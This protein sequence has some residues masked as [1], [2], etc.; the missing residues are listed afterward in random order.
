M[1][2]TKTITAFGLSMLALS[3]MAQNALNDVRLSPQGLNTSPL[4]REG[5]L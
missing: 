4:K 5:F 2:L 3:A 1:K